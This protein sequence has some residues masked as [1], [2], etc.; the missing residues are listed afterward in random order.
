MISSQIAASAQL[1]EFSS[2]GTVLWDCRLGGN[3]RMVLASSAN[4]G[5]FMQVPSEMRKCV[6]FLCYTKSGNI[7]IVGTAFFVGVPISDTK[8]A[9]YVVTARH[10][11]LEID[12]RNFEDPQKVLLR[13]NMMDGTA[14]YLAIAR[15]AWVFPNENSDVAVA[16]CGLPEEFDQAVFPVGSFA[17]EDVIA[18]ESIGIGEEV[19]LIG[20]F[21]K[22]FGKGK[23]SPILRVGNI[24]AMPD[25]PVATERLGQ[26]E[27][28]LI[29][30]RSIG[31]ISGS[32]VFVSVA[33][34]RSSLS[35]NTT[36]G[37]RP[38]YF[39]LGLMHGHWNWDHSKD[40][41]VFDSGE[42]STDFNIDHINTGI[43]V[44]VPASKIL[45][46][47]HSQPFV[48]ARE[49]LTKSWELQNSPEPD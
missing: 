24:A 37:G 2:P 44:V 6:A 33:G 45:S 1:P 31:G 9:A 35:G 21:S 38:R 17:T 4:C 13:V 47:I 8:S 32:P 5:V 34:V 43:A 25:E 11:L 20:L 42:P 29:E 23:N 36:I 3:P 18:R 48:A 30:A 27:A 28:Y 41:P 16:P 14:G 22:H 15:A 12:D 39:L 49:A 40:N 19:F 7:Q 10:N 46:V 26:I